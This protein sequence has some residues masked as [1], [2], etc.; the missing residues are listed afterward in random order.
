[1]IWRARMG[2]KFA[3]NSSSGEANIKCPTEN[4]RFIVVRYAHSRVLIT[5]FNLSRSRGTLYFG[6]SQQAGRNAMY[7]VYYH[8]KLGKGETCSNAL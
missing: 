7:Y 1:M 8:V 5:S 4:L 3:T 6:R 2:A